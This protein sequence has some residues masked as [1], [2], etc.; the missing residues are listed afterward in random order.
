[1]TRKKEQRAV[2]RAVASALDLPMSDAEAVKRR[3]GEG[4]ADPRA[5]SPAGAAVDELVTEIHN[6]IR[7]FS[8]LPG[9][10]SVSRVSVT[11]GGARTAGFMAG[12]GCPMM[13]RG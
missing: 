2:T 7:F 12:A 5:E 10:G 11:G 6:S 9:R 8:S 1:M 13:A 4:T 3:L